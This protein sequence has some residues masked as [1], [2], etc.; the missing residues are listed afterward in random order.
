MICDWLLN[1][2]YCNVWLFDWFIKYLITK[3]KSSPAN[4]IDV[5]I[6]TGIHE[7]LVK[8]STHKCFGKINRDL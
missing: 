4:D 7:I 8:I 5:N 6:Q 2:D 1:S 3:R